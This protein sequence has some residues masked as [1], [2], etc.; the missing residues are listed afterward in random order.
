MLEN[1]KVTLNR[2]ML[3]HMVRQ[4]NTWL[5]KNEVEGV[6]E[7]Y[8]V[9]VIF[10]LASKKHQLLKIKG[11]SWQE[12]IECAACLQKEGSVS[13]SVSQSLLRSPAEN[14]QPQIVGRKGL[15]VQGHWQMYPVWTALPH[16][17]RASV[18]VLK[19]PSH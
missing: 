5:K 9:Q 17:L 3:Y 15:L 8:L 2:E 18:P 13:A 1:P 4:L 19:K 6:Q 14:I 12:W 11:H 7:A 16:S 10:L